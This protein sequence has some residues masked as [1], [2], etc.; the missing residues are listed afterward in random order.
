MRHM[1]ENLQAVKVNIMY[2]MDSGDLLFC[3]AGFALHP[4]FTLS[5]SLCQTLALIT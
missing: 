1:A 2:G 3:K 5:I 4:A